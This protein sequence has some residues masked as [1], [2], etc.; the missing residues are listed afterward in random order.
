MIAGICART[1]KEAMMN[2][3]KF[4]MP[5]AERF[6]QTLE[7]EELKR[8]F[9]EGFA[10]GLAAGA[11]HGWQDVLLM[12][13][14]ARGIPLSA[15]DEARIRAC[16]DTAKL[17]RWIERAATASSVREVLGQ[18]SSAPAARRRSTKRVRAA[19]ASRA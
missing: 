13:L 16:A 14:Q 8:G 15:T 6:I 2:R 9:S 10:D 1:C 12:T 7:S 3:D 11:V 17:D 4:R 18:R 19:S 5:A